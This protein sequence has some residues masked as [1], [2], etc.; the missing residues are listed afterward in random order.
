MDHKVL[1]LNG[2]YTALA[3]T[4]VQKAFVLLYLEKADLIAPSSHGTLRTVNREYA[5][6][7]VIRLH[8]YVRVP[9]K[10]ITLSRHNLMRRDNFECQYCG[11]T[12]NL[13]LDHMMPRSRGGDSGWTNLLT[14]CSRCNHK[15]GDRTP[16]EA[17]MIPRQRPRRPTLA[18]FLRSSAGH[19]DEA[20]HTYLA[21]RAA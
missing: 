13:T 12:R 5:R 6:P 15:K 4:S 8:R 2:D 11:S 19:L 9:Y 21:E 18:S 16:E 3:L 10:G 14:A 7:S 1:V 17:G 20:W